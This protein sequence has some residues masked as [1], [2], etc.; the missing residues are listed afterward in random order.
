[1][2]W[3]ETIRLLTPS[4]HR[5]HRAPFMRTVKVFRLAHNDRIIFFCFCNSA[6]LLCSVF[7]CF[8]LLL[9]VDRRR[10]FFLLLLLLIIIIF[11]F[12]FYSRIGHDSMFVSWPIKRL[13]V[14]PSSVPTIPSSSSSSYGL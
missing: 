1:V 2:R 4:T 5:W 6:H 3:T 10:A 11:L 12:S 14:A 7:N 13:D 9:Y 8:W